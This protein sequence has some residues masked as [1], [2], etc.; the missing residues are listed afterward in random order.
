[1][2]QIHPEICEAL[3]KKYPVVALET[4]IITHGLPYPKNLATAQLLEQCV[5]EEG[6]IPATIGVVDGKLKVGFSQQELVSLASTKGEKLQ[7][8]YL[9]WA[10]A[11]GLSGGTTVSATMHIAQLAGIQVFA[12]GG[13]GGVHREAERTF[14]ISEDLTALANTPVAVVSAG[15]KAI[16]DLPLTLEKLETLGVPVL[17]YQTSEFPAFYTRSSGLTIPAVASVEDMAA[18]LHTAWET[19]HTTTGFLICNPPPRQV[20]LPAAQVEG[21]IQQ[22]LAAARQAKI[23]GKALTPFLLSHLEQA[24]GGTTVATNVALV[25][26]NARVA[27]K[28]AKALCRLKGGIL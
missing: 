5:R 10:V 25:E 1:M 7:A 14:D 23:T 13:I 12:T 28:I 18:I 21:F 20:E 17:G 9:A 3:A 26:S 16:L 24:S 4:T 2:L 8:R 27:A 11:L 6:A 15:A 19:L 22:A